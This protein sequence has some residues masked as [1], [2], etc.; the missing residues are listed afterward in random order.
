MWRLT[1]PDAAAALEDQRVRRSL[2]RYI[3]VVKNEKLAKFVM[4]KSMEVDYA[5]EASSD[6]LWSVHGEALKE[7]SSFEK[8]IDSGKEHVRVREGVTSF[9]DLKVELARRVM[10]GCVFCVRR[11]GFD[12]LSGERG[13]CRGGL[14]FSVSSTFPHLG[15]EPELVPSGTVFTCG[16]TITCIHCQNWGISQWREHGTPVRPDRMA[17]LVESLMRQGCRNLNMVGGDP[18]PN[19]YLW[20]DTFRHVD[21]SIATVWN[22]NSYEGR[23]PKTAFNLPLIW[24]SNSY[25]S[26]ET[27]ELLAGFID[28]YLLDFKYGNN[29]CSTEISNAPGYWE[30]CMRN[31]MMALKHGE[32][33]IRVLVLP[34]HNE[35]CTRPIL[36]WIADN[37]GPWTRVNLMFQYRPE[38]RARERS[39]LSRRLNRMEIKEAQQIAEAVGLKNLVRG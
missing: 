31:H 38:W 5:Q 15:E 8:E 22:S 25:Y 36:K 27:A 14:E 28:V 37:L 24:N 20:L 17:D 19:T 1:R 39:E 33:I 35:C 16:C 2:P 32:L 9:L 29:T 21:E 10:G 7:Y 34:E 18:T 4:A 11:C 26:Q 13:Y 3:D 30:A 12:R 23:I 6:E